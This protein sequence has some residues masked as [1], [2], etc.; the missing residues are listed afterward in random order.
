MF[1][2]LS[3]KIFTFDKRSKMKHSKAQSTFHANC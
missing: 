3:P 2:W 1:H